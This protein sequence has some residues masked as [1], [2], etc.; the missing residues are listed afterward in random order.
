MFRYIFIYRTSSDSLP[1]SSNCLTHC[2]VSTDFQYMW[3]L[4]LRCERGYM[5]WGEIALTFEWL[6]CLNQPTGLVTVECLWQCFKRMYKFTQPATWSYQ[7]RPQHQWRSHPPQERTLPA[8][9]LLTRFP[10]LVKP[11]FN[12][13]INLTQAS[14]SRLYQVLERLSNRLH[15][16]PAKTQ[17]LWQLGTQSTPCLQPNIIEEWQWYKMM[18]RFD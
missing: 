4:D 7:C 13:Q 12:R 3:S 6:I 2:F 10:V 17:G 18:L 8:P 9:Q 16:P 15:A 5:S 14:T 1:I 11:L